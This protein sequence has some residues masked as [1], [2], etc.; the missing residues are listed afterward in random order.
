MSQSIKKIL[1]GCLLVSLSN[2]ALAHSQLG[3]LGKARSGAA[4]ADIYQVDCS[5]DGSGKPG[6]LYFHV[7][8]NLERDPK[9]KVTW[10]VI[11]KI[12]IQAAKDGAK[13]AFSVDPIDGDKKYSKALALAK[14]AGSYL[15]TVRKAAALATCKAT[16]KAR[17]LGIDTYKVEFHC[18]TADGFHT[19]T[20]STLRRNQ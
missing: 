11:P 7:I 16:A 2:V 18:E 20:E 9:T 17:C 1:L 12:S 13:T 10:T 14:G 3:S 4:A 8:D 19:G 6:Y 5:D 15:V